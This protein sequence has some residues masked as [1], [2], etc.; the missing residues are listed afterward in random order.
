[1][2]SAARNCM[3]VPAPVMASIALANVILDRLTLDVTSSASE[4]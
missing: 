4:T 2:V 3:A 1:M